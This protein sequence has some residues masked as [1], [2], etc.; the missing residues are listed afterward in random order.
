MEKYI[1][2]DI[3]GVLDGE[4]T[5][6]EPSENDI[7]LFDIGNGL[8]Q[9]LKNGVQSINLLNELTQHHNYKIILYS[10]NKE[11]ETLDFIEIIANQAKFKGCQNR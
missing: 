5:N 10:N 1:I 7:A 8:L 11:K 3:T 9:V 2:I 4:I 6:E